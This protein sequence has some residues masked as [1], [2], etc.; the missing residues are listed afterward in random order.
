MTGEQLRNSI[1]QLA[2]QGKLVE[3]REEEGTAEELYEQIQ[4]EKERLILEGKL[5]K[6]KKLPEISEDEIHF[7]IPKSWKWF[8]ISQISDMYTGNSIA[9]SIKKSKY[10]NI[11]K[12]YEYIGTK[13]VEFN[14]KINYDNGIKIPFDEEKF[15]RAYKNSILMCIEG[16]SAGRKIAFLDKEV[17]FG[18]KLCSFNAI[19]FN[20]KYLYYYLKSVTFALF[21]KSRVNGIIGGVSIL[22][23]KTILIPFPPL[24][25]QKRIAEK[26]EELMPYVEKYDLMNS[27]LKEM[28]EKFPEEIKKSILQFAIQGKLV[29][30]RE[31]E[32]TAE[33]LYE[34]IQREKER[35]ISEGKLKKQK[36][37]PEISEDEIPFEIPK[38]WKW[39]RLG[40]V[41]NIIMGQSPVGESINTEN[42]GVEFHQGKIYFDKD[43]IL[44]SEY[45]TSKPTKIVEAN[46]VLL[47]V[48]APVGILNITNRTICIG[49]GLCGI[50]TFKNIDPKFILYF[51]RGFE[52]DFIK[53]A[54]GT[55]FIA[56]TVE[57]IKNQVFPL[58]P[59]EE[60]KR[61]VEKIE[62]LF[63]LIYNH[64]KKV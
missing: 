23:L 32:G 58:P 15:K 47:C 35:L 29:E 55:T 53:K 20:S 27:E 24:A 37:L 54:T 60:Q 64:N 50:D 44:E 45:F 11:D 39:V 4:R 1:L 61:I 3:Q 63:S 14:G 21:F 52:Q 8:Y 36:K 57:V 40:E 25:E 41:F 46:T 49:R 19:K 31:E 62:K 9:D 26:I 18:N 2:I 6:Q 7:K 28:D 5:K 33:E 48:R 34:Q 42:N 38:S 16:G 43:Y 17:C 10:S 12:G 13:D 56:I 22:K 51:L 30:Q 59:L